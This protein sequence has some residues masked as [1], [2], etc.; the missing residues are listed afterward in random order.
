MNRRRFVR[1]APPPERT[2]SIRMPGILGSLGR[3]L[4]VEWIDVSEGGL[5]AAVSR[6]LGPGT[7]V[8]VRIEC[9]PEREAFEVE[10]EIGHARPSGRH[11]GAW[12]IGGR[13]LS[14][15]PVL[16]AAIRGAELRAPKRLGLA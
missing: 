13:F 15:S 4:L 1:F 10:L 12:E 3:N 16:R 2:L 6:E 8:R 7:R 9:V 5:R 14:P 11:P